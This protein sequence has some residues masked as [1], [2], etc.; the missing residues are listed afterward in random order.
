MVPIVSCCSPSVLKAK[1]HDGHYSE[2]PMK[3][4]SLGGDWEVNA[5]ATLHCTFRKVDRQRK[6]CKKGIDSTVC[7]GDSD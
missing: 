1:P 7:L 2:G 5:V 4:M 6:V 3:E